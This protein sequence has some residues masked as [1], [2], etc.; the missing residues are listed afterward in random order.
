[1]TYYKYSLFCTTRQ[2]D[3]WGMPVEGGEGEKETEE[4][5]GKRV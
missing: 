1:M 3:L 4:R 2:T 5:Q